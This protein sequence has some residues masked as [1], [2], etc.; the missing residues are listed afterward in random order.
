MAFK[1]DDLTEE[2]KKALKKYLDPKREGISP[3]SRDVRKAAWIDGYKFALIESTGQAAAILEEGARELR[4]LI[5]EL[6]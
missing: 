4:S 2:A 6:K 5:S 1:E 3:F